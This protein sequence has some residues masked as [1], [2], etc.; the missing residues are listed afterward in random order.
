LF[1]S[2]YHKIQRE[3]ERE[4]ETI[5]QWDKN[6]KRTIEEEKKMEKATKGKMLN[7]I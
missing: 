2:C 4:R 5:Y 3:R 1:L 7:T 6:G